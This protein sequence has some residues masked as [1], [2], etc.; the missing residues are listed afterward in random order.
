MGATGGGVT[1][2]D[3][4]FGTGGL[5]FGAGAGI[6][7][8]GLGFSSFLTILR[9]SFFTTLLSGI[10]LAFFSLAGALAISAVLAVALDF[11]I[12]VFSVLLS[13][14][15]AAFLAVVDFDWVFAVVT[16]TLEGTL[17]YIFAL[18]FFTTFFGVVLGAKRSRIYSAAS[19]SMELIW[20]FTGILC[21]CRASMI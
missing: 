13:D 19:P 1:S 12:E 5:T 16:F 10:F 7:S 2:G 14:F 4:T 20:F 9:P 15:F 21:F 17:I 8:T 11:G 18:A 6:F 3:L